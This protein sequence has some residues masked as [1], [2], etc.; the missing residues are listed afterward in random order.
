M[1]ETVKSFDRRTF[2]KGGIVAAAAAA[3]GS[4]LASCSPQATEGVASAEDNADNMQPSAS[5]VAVGYANPDGIGIPVAPD[6]TEDVDVVVMGS[7]MAALRRPCLSK[8]KTPM[9]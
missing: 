7:G 4:L 5:R 8:N 1:R 9:R 2:M 3:T 6:S